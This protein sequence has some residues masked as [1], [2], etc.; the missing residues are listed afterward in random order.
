MKKYLYILGLSLV[1]IVSSA[2]GASTV[3][4]EPA[5]VPT[6]DQSG[7]SKSVQAAADAVFNR[8]KEANALVETALS[9]TE[10]Q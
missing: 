4:N 9:A 6:P 2:A 1:G 10:T 3:V 8:T 5:P 7:A